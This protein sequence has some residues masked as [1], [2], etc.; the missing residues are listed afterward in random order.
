MKRII[1]KIRY[2]IRCI[3]RMDYKR[4]FREIDEMH[5]KCG[6]SKIRLFFS[7]VY[8]GLRFGSG[9]VDY[10]LYEF[11][12][13]T[14]AQRATYVTRGVNNAI[15]KRYN[16]KGS[17]HILENKVE[18]NRYFSDYMGRKWI[19][20]PGADAKEFAR[21]MEGLDII[22][23]KPLDASGGYGIEKLRRAD[24]EST[25][26][27]FAYLNEHKFGLAEEFIVQVP[28][29]NAITPYSVNT[30]RIC[31][32]CNQGEANVLYFYIRMGNGKSVV[33]N[34]HQG[35]ITCPV[36]RET[37]RTT[38][39]GYACYGGY[40]TFDKHP[41]TGF[42]LVGFEVPQWRES[43]ALALEV[44]K[45]IPQVGYVGWDIAVTEKGPVL[46]E[47]NPFPG[48]DLT[49]LPPHVGEDGC[50]ILPIYKKYIPNL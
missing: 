36:D 44:A 39:K 38:A 13:K 24:F 12:N 33:D 11:Y 46:I 4:L 50:G 42:D 6:K 17:T 8:C 2:L 15:V 34:L 21:F 14:N 41:E 9:H 23:A 35:G 29:M 28:E 3:L 25:D 27:M 20:I 5:E 19:E 26:A 18:F 47:G 22:M 48:H 32:I 31:T 49:Q 16:D 1:N 45:K 7:V 40:Y 10:I 43:I 37:G 30:Y